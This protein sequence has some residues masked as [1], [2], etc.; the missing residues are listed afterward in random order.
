MNRNFQLLKQL[1]SARFRLSTR[2]KVSPSCVLRSGRLFGKSQTS[3]NFGS[4][5]G[6]E[7]FSADRVSSE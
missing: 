4:L 3:L 2:L 5:R 6:L 7:K 1:A